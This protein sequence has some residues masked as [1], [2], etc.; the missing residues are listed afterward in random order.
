M[1][2]TAPTTNTRRIDDDL[3]DALQAHIDELA[4]QYGIQ[5]AK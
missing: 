2:T 3:R 5:G 4:A 1:D